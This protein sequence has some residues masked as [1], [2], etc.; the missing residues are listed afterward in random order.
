MNRLCKLL[1]IFITFLFMSCTTTIKS[2]VTQI[3][4]T[5]YI[6]QEG[7]GVTLKPPFWD[8]AVRLWQWVTD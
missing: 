2:P 1:F 4:Y 3:E 6:K 7:L 5:G 8:Y